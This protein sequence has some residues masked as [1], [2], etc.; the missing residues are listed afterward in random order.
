MFFRQYFE[1]LMCI[2]TIKCELEVTKVFEPLSP[3]LGSKLGTTV[4]KTYRVEPN[5]IRLPPLTDSIYG[6][7]NNISSEGIIPEFERKIRFLSKSSRWRTTMKIR[8]TV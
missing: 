8:G 1:P 2:L 7:R 5:L 6:Q 4:H 3:C